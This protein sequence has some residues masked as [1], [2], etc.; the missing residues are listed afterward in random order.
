MRQMVLVFAL[1][2]ALSAPAVEAEKKVEDP[3]ARMEEAREKV[4]RKEIKVKLV[5]L[6]MVGKIG[7]E[8]FVKTYKTL[9]EQRDLLKY[10]TTG[11]ST[12][13]ASMV[14]ADILYVLLDSEY[15]EVRALAAEQI[16]RYAIY[17]DQPRAADRLIHLMES[18][19]PKERLAAV[20]AFGHLIKKKAIPQ[21]ADVKPLDMLERVVKFFK[22]KDPEVLSALIRLFPNTGNE[23]V[24]AS[25]KRLT[26]HD[27]PEVRRLAFVFFARREI[28][29]E[30]VRKAA[31]ETLGEGEDY[32]L[33]QRTAARYLGMVKDKDAVPLLG[34]LLE[35]YA[36]AKRTSDDDNVR[37]VKKPILRALPEI[38]GEEALKLCVEFVQTKEPLELICLA[39]VAVET[40]TGKELGYNYHM[41]PAEGKL[42]ARK[43]EAW[44]ISDYLKEGEKRK[45]EL[46]KLRA[47]IAKLEVDL[48]P[49][50]VVETILLTR[51][52]EKRMEAIRAIPE[53][54]IEK[55][56]KEAAEMKK[57]SNLVST[58]GYA[59]GDIEFNTMVME[60]V[61]HFL[62]NEDPKTQYMAISAIIHS[63]QFV[64]R[65]KA[66]PKLELI[67]NTGD[68]M[69]RLL[70]RRAISMLRST[71]QIKPDRD[72]DKQ[73]PKKKKPP[74]KMAPGS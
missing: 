45:E 50:I 52:N 15:G 70:A 3:K 57:S 21:R 54:G 47:E 22:D 1:C 41:V 6:M 17:Y 40:I 64:D 44:Y 51:K 20:K 74:K 5:G 63:A 53:I 24:L 55:V 9:D 48:Q 69:N 11:S 12:T 67:S 32:I 29:D 36:G 26:G 68:E 10:V 46:E 14:R 62:D 49:R 58:M 8:E 71:T 35:D 13:E 2:F 7:A 60:L 56:A 31:L 66:L 43:F 73:T 61:S 65:E 33:S 39:G 28:V 30:D 18:K 37:R 4:A 34:K 38:G 72:K 23:K 42:A 19:D 16:F 59:K 27:D 25:I